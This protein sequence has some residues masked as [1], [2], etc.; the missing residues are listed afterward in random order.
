MEKSG[1]IHCLNPY[2]AVNTV[3]ISTFVLKLQ[4]SYSNPHITHIKQINENF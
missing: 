2:G 3:A 1:E 4:H